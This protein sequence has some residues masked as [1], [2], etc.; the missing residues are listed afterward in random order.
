VKNQFVGLRNPGANELIYLLI[1]AEPV[2]REDSDIYRVICT[3]HDI[4]E[5]KD[6]EEKL[7]R[8]NQKIN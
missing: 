3:Y 1:S 5:R 6:A 8:S 4:T 7:E 2:L